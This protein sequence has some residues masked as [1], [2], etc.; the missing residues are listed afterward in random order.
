MHH[1]GK[2]VFLL[3]QGELASNAQLVE[4]RLYSEEEEEEEQKYG[5]LNL[6]DPSEFSQP[7]FNQASGLGYT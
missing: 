6:L 3:F 2:E 1:P 5:G 4:L 7:K